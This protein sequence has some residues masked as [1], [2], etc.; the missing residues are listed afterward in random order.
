MVCKRMSS[1]IHRECS[2]RL[3]TSTAN[4]PGHMHAY[5]R[6]QTLTLSNTLDLSQAVC[7]G[8][9]QVSSYLLAW[10]GVLLNTALTGAAVRGII[11]AAIHMD[12][13]YFLDSEILKNA[14]VAIQGTTAFQRPKSLK[15]LGP[16]F[17][18]GLFCV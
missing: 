5:A 18:L 14:I 4:H 8:R 15:G 12:L 7:F 2:H 3:D 11:L 16:E 13:G 17:G 9:L 6:T 1:K 10:P